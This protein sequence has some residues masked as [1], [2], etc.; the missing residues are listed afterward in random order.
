MKEKVFFISFVC[1]LSCMIIYLLGGLVFSSRP[2]I[3][4]ETKDYIYVKK[5]ALYNRDSTVY[6]YHQPIKYDGIVTKKYKYG[7]FMGVP[8]K[9]GHFVHHYHID[10]QFNNTV[11][12]LSGRT[13]Y[14][15]F[16]EGDKVIVIEK[17]WPYNDYEYVL[18]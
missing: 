15:M 5:Y 1:I 14:D 7:A 6:K 17:F 16:N 8:G 3:V 11:H 9:G 13:Y 18:K 2:V 4:K 10:I 12:K